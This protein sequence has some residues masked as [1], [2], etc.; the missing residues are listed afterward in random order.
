MNTLKF[1]LFFLGVAMTTASAIDLHTAKSQGLVCE[2]ADGF[3]VAV[4][5]SPEIESLVQRVNSERRK[6]Y[7]QVAAHN[8]TR[9]EAAASLAGQKLQQEAP[10]R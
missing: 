5:H 4:D 8:G 7:S 6:H 3:L 10:C 9:P 1:F 2:G